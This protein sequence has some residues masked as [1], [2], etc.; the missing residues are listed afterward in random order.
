MWESPVLYQISHG[1]VYPGLDVLQ[2]QMSHFFSWLTYYLLTLLVRK[3]FFLISSVNLPSCS[4]W[5][6]LLLLPFDTTE[7]N[8]SQ[9]SSPLLNTRARTSKPASTSQHLY[10]LLALIVE[11]KSQGIH[12]G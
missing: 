7:M 5:L 8:L 11:K 10:T 4:V 3:T 1:F 9:P 6:L 2:G 12:A